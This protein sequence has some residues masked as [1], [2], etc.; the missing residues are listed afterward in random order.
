MST[1]Y[2]VVYDAAQVKKFA[3][4]F[5]TGMTRDSAQILSFMMREKYSDEK[6]GSSSSQL[7]Q[8]IVNCEKSRPDR[9]LGQIYRFECAVEA[10]FYETPEKEYK[11]VPVGSTVVYMTLNRKSILSGWNTTMK[12]VM[13]FYRCIASAALGGSE[14][15]TS[16]DVSKIDA[17]FRGNVHA[18][19]VDKIYTDFDVDTKER[20][21]LASIREVIAPVLGAIV[22]I[23]E[24]RVAT[25][26]FARR[27]NWAATRRICTTFQLR[28]FLK[29]RIATENR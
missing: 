7:S 11:N 12:S 3:Q 18:S 16:L 19:T 22:A 5:C 24:T 23:V 20:D 27:Q 4:T 29:R 1:H 8:V 21:K 6:M 26:L 14:K 2:K 15:G 17:I 13:D 9:F 28:Q 10:Y 25:T